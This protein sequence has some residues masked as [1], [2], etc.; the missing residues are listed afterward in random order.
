MAASS[1]WPGG[2]ADL[3]KLFM[4]GSL[5][6]A[7]NQTPCAAAELKRETVAAFDQYVQLTEARMGDDVRANQFLVVDRLSN[8][9]SQA[10][11]E[12]LRQ[13]QIYIQELRTWDDG[14]GIHIPGGLVHHWAA[15]IFIPNATLPEALAVLEDYDR[16]QD[17]YQP[18][19]RRSKLIQR[20]GD[21]SQIYMQFYNKSIVTVILNVN[22]DVNETD[23]GNTEAQ[24]ASRSTRIAELA[25]LGQPDEH[26][27]PVGNDHG[28][29]WRL[30]S[31]WR[32]E[33]KD[34]GVYIQNE[35]MAL[36]RSI[37]FVLAW[38]VNPLTRSIPRNFL[39]DLLVDT[40]IAL[41]KEI[42]P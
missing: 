29:M 32:I 36:T 24:I 22:F 26:E 41:L 2:C 27:L 39:R 42:Q 30:D 10:A 18:D 16:H 23:F 3:L 38:L 8:P 11:Y 34:G 17:I 21:K 25:N 20:D 33:E 12:Q 7:L 4:L 37:P 6:V 9:A 5:T 19:V 35:S 1:I 31:Y 13:G 15:V 14:H 40:R 28:Y